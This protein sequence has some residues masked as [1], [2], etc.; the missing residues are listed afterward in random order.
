MI[1]F[2]SNT[3]GQNTTGETGCFE[4]LYPFLAQQYEKGTLETKPGIRFHK[5]EPTDSFWHLLSLISLEQNMAICY[6]LKV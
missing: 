3:V 6:N 5:K 1:R 2:R 4:H